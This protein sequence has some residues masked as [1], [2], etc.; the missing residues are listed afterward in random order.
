ML[1]AELDPELLR[2]ARVPIE[3]KCPRGMKEADILSVRR[4]DTFGEI[5]GQPVRK[6][7]GHGSGDG[8]SNASVPR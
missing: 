2:K 7:E 3:V 5:L 4:V 8:Q 6:K 1:I